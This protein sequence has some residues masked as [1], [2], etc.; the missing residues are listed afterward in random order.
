MRQRTVCA[1]CGPSELE[2]LDA[3]KTYKT[4]QS[5]ETIVRAG[6]KMEFLGFVMCGVA[7]LSRDLID[8]RR[9]IIRLLLPSDFIGGLKQEVSPFEIV[10]IGEVT[11]CKLPKLKFEAMV[12]SSPAL[13]HRFLEIALDEL[14]AAREWMLLL[15]RKSAR[16]KVASLLVVLA[17]HDAEQNGHSP[18][19]GLFFLVLLTRETMANYLALTLETV[20]RQFSALNKDGVI[21][22]GD[23]GY[24]RVPD[25]AK[26]LYEA[27]DDTD[28]GIIT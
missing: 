2:K 9:Q 8:G 16:E 3:I 19:D 22:L 14:D 4:Y 13:E 23:L 15:G 25:Y 28:G 21:V 20:S 27:A 1:N 24:V 17:N 6:Y 7:A 10:A 11:I 12:L 26:L 5:G 18:A